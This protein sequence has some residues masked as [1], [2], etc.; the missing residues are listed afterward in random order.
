VDK[1]V[2][3]RK[4]IPRAAAE[5]VRRNSVG[6]VLLLALPWATHCHSSAYLSSKCIFIAA[7]AC[8]KHVHGV[9][10]ALAY[11]RGTRGGFVLTSSVSWSSIVLGSIMIDGITIMTTYLHLN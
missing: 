7:S 11:L 2:G 5:V 3:E 8:T 6:A 10:A 4:V 9:A 1:D